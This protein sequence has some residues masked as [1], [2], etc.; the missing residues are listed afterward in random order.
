METTKISVSLFLCLKKKSIKKEAL[1]F[2]KE[3]LLFEDNFRGALDLESEDQGLGP[4]SFSCELLLLLSQLQF[5]CPSNT[6]MMP[7]SQG[8]Y[9]D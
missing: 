7:T 3:S 2:K 9:E 6:G 4:G 1:F 8:C 5:F